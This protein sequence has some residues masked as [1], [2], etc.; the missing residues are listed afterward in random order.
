MNCFEARNDFV[1]FWQ[2][3]LSIERLKA[4]LTH[5]RRCGTCDHAF[6]IFA[7]TAPILYSAIEPDG[8]LG[9]A[10]PIGASGFDL[11]SERRPIVGRLTRVWPI[12][13]MAAA[14]A[15]TLYFAASPRMTFEDEIGADQSN[16]E[17]ASYPSADSV[18]GQE[19][20]AQ[21]TTATDLSEE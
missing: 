5:L 18:F 17:L 6:R 10:R 12:F 7:L 20:M 3:T 1:A 9:L 8:N 11:S 14:A 19:L 16:V 4:L 15:I 2:K 13:A 21:G